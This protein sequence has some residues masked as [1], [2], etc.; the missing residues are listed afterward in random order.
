MDFAWV[1]IIKDKTSLLSSNTIQDGFRGKVKCKLCMNVFE[2]SR[3]L[4]A[5]IASLDTELALRVKVSWS[6]SQV[7]DGPSHVKCFYYLCIVFSCSI[8]H[9]W[10]KFFKPLLS[11]F[12]MRK[13]KQIG[14]FSHYFFRWWAKQ[15]LGKAILASFVKIGLSQ[16]ILNLLCNV[17]WLYLFVSV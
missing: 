7:A 3:I 5:W 4:L 11:I 10:P 17:F 6:P 2:Y 16:I 1:K 14:H 15:L 13:S 9:L 12:I 8:L